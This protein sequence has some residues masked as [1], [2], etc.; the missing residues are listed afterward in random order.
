HVLPNPGMRTPDFTDYAR[1]NPGTN[2]ILGHMGF[3]PFDADAI[4]FAAELDNLY[5]ET[6]LG[7]Y[8]ALRDA[9]EKLG[10]TKL[11]FGSE[12]PLSHP[13]AELEKILLLDAAA[14]DAILKTNILRLLQL[15]T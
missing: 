7:N 9:L 15:E 13:R 3:G 14:H 4:E 1:R 6:S 5:L 2:F 10:P 8:L 12:F 11:I